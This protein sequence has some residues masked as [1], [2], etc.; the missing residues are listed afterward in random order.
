MFDTTTTTTTDFTTIPVT[1]PTSGPR[2][3][4]VREAVTLGFN[5]HGDMQLVLSPAFI[6]DVPT[7]AVGNKIVVGFHAETQRLLLSLPKEGQTAGLRTVRTRQGFVGAGCITVSA[8]NVP[9]A[10]PRVEKRVPVTNWT[11][12]DE[13]AVML[14]LANLAS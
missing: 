2:A 10:L 3:P 14:H 1:R 9:E 12:E 13:G 6:E 7:L 8:R 11:L 5:K 4:R